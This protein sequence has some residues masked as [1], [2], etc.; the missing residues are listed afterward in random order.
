MLDDMNPESP[1]RLR[2]SRELR[3]IRAMH[4]EQAMHL[5]TLGFW[6]LSAGIKVETRFA[7]ASSTHQADINRKGST[8]S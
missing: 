1:L 4:S 2:L 7:T 3:E 6:L 8:E 5:S